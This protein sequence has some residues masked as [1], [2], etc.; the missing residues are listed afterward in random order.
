MILS[1]ALAPGQR[2]T[3]A[4][5]ADLLGVSRTPIR[6]ALPT[7]AAEGLVR[8]VGRR[9]YAVR[10]FNEHESWEALELRA[11]LEGQAARMVAQKGASEAL[12][13]DLDV[14]LASGDALFEKRH[15]NPEDEVAYGIMNAR[16]HQLVIDACESAMLRTFIERLNIV[17]F[18]APS[19]VVFDQIGLDRAYDLLFGAHRVHHAIVDAIRDGDGQRAETLFREHAHQQKFSMFE[20]SRK[21]RAISSPQL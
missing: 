15:L 6:N 11:L 18:V 8:N 20:R 19:V 1:G 12:L 13:T 14:C 21:R 7:L 5:L 9:G 2:V 16:F 4:G 17:P 3:E 10:E